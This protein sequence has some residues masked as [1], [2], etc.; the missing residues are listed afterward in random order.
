MLSYN[1][2]CGSRATYPVNTAPMAIEQLLLTIMVLIVAA[3][4]E[5]MDFILKIMIRNWVLW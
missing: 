5:K 1:S 3:V 2:F 4:V